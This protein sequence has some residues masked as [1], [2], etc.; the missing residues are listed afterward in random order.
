[1]AK[2]GGTDYIVLRQSGEGWVEAG[3]TNAAHAESAVRVCMGSEPG[4]YRA[5]PL[6]SWHTPLR[7]SVEKVP[8]VRVEPV[9]S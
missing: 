3:R 6:R 1:M 7:L 8:V 9:E 5:V 4:I 2:S